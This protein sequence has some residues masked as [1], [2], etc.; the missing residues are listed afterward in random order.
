MLGRSKSQEEEQEEEEQQEEE[1]EQ[2]EQEE[3]EGEEFPVSSPIAG[4]T[5]EK[6]LRLSESWLVILDSE[7]QRPRAC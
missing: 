7:V 5:L 6:V 1:A 2:V 4:P 3:E